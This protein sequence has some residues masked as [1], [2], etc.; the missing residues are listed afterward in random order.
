MAAGLGGP[1]RRRVE[2]SSLD[3]SR[4]VWSWQEEGRRRVEGSS[5]GGSRAVGTWEEKGGGGILF[6]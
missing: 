3:G 5:L 6:V 2:G 1:G 4:A